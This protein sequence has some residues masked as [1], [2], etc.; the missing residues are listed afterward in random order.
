MN[1][2]QRPG[3]S[4]ISIASTPQELQNAALEIAKDPVGYWTRALT[5]LITGARVIGSIASTSGAPRINL[6][7]AYSRNELLEVLQ[8]FQPGGQRVQLESGFYSVNELLDMVQRF[9]VQIAGNGH[10][11]DEETIDPLLAAGI[12][13]QLAQQTPKRRGRRAS[14]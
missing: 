10:A 3:T 12:P 11:Q 5:S 2:L 14:A 8:Q 1:V 7:G 13:N 4:T 6:Q 9:P